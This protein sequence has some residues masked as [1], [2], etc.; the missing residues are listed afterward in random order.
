MS[1]IGTLLPCNAS[2]VH[3]S[4]KDGLL[5]KD[6]AEGKPVSFVVVAKG[7]SGKEGM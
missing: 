5:T 1:I 2:A 4:V 6:T 3:S 7:T